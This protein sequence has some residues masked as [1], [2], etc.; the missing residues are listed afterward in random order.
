M[1][2]RRK[3]RVTLG[4]TPSEHRKER[5]TY[6]HL[7][8]RAV[9][10]LER[11]SGSCDNKLSSI[12]DAERLIAKSVTHAGGVGMPRKAPYVQSKGPRA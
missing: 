8:E 4:S 12:I 11:D 2:K 10:A 6:F 5:D 3:R 1:A 7:A 9:I